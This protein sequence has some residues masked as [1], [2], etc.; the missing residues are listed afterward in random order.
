M[1]AC[2]YVLYL[3]AYI[4]GLFLDGA[5][6]DRRNRKLTESRPKVLQDPMPVVG[7]LIHK[8]IATCS[9]KWRLKLQQKLAEIPPMRCKIF[10]CFFYISQ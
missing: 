2:M 6:W 9:G 1:S 5:C 8:I 7:L 10:S 4:S 3:G